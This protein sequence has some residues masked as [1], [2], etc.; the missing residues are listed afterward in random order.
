MRRSLVAGI[1][2]VLV[3][4]LVA[5]ATAAAKVRTGPAGA[6]FYAPPSPLPKG[7]HGAPI[8]QRPLS[9]QATLKGGANSLLLYR[10]TGL[11]GKGVAVS[12][13][14]T[15][16]RGKAPSGGWP[17]VTWAHATSGLADAC[18]P[19]RAN[20]LL[21][22]DHPLLERWLKAG[23]AIVRTDY[24][25]LGT[26]GPHPYL[27]GVT[28]GRAVLDAVLAA[29]VADPRIGAKVLISGHSQGGQAALF[30]AAL[31]PRWAPSLDVRGTVAFAPASHLSE[32]LSALATSG[33][34]GG[35]AL[36][37]MALRGLDVAQP[38]L[39]VA[40]LLTPQAA[41]LYPRIDADCLAALSGADAFGGLPGAQLLAPGADLAPIARALA[42]DDPED[43]TIR[44]P[45]LIE[46]GT[47]DTTVPP[48]LTEQTARSLK[49]T[50]KTYAGLTH[51]SLVLSATP[52]S[53]A[54]AFAERRLR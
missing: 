38:G 53:D 41:A 47:A 42:A 33:A 23:Y 4:V 7:T 25:G 1:V 16:P 13:V 5:A 45:L 28:E 22:Y 51:V 14:L 40:A 6:A 15:V 44:T 29:R 8:W 17:I 3:V 18:A 43:L 20:V 27:D 11:A 31:A 19:S 37:A 10:S 21:G 30:A 48:A 34:A 26:P 46:Q 12:A 50:Y 32:Q 35:T 49:A 9:G 24:Q 52:Q 2:L 54:V 39:H 36:A